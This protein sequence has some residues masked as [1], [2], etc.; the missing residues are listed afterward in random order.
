[1]LL[2]PHGYL[3]L[4]PVAVLPG[5]HVSGTAHFHRTR[6]MA[7]SF[8][9]SPLAP[10][11]CRPALRI[12]RTRSSRRRLGSR[13]GKRFFGT[14]DLTT[15]LTADRSV[16]LAVGIR[17]STDKSFPL[18]FCAGSR[19][20]VCDN[21]AFNAELL[22]K[23]K[24]TRLA[25]GRWNNE[26]AAA[27]QKLDSFK[28]AETLRIERLMSTDLSDDQALAFIVRAMEKYVISVPTVP[29]I[30]T[31]WR[32]PTHD[33]GTGD[34]PTAWKLLNCFTT[35]LGKERAVRSPNEYAVQTIRL[36]ALICPSAEPANAA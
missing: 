31:E 22:V 11:Y 14:L 19:V 27:V 32:T 26:I 3:T 24:H 10:P 30:L 25:V 35:V 2:K 5:F 21:L 4:S 33:Y 28:E 17:N 6:P 18:G 12:P 9:V 1:L 16:A 29:K 36:N 20:T 7:P 34:R 13:D 15:G 8:V 23:R